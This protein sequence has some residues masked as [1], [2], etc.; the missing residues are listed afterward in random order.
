ME[1]DKNPYQRS[2]Y[3]IFTPSFISGSGC[4]NWLWLDGQRS[5][6]DSVQFS[7]KLKT[8]LSFCNGFSWQQVAWL[9]FQGPTLSII[10]V[11]QHP[12]IVDRWIIIF[13]EQNNWNDSGLTNLDRTKETR[14]SNR[15][16][17]ANICVHSVLGSEKSCFLSYSGIRVFQIV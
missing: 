7:N 14:G 16:C 10:Q 6:G 1:G 11:F 15:K 8:E 2:Q 12:V 9:E 3:L 4:G 13:L 17:A 5:S